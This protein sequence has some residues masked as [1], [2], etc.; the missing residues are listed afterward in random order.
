MKIKF[1]AV[2]NGRLKGIFTSWD[3]CEKS[4]KGYKGA[5]FKSFKLH[6][7]A[8]MFL[9]KYSKPTKFNNKKTIKKLKPLSNVK[10]TGYQRNKSKSGKLYRSI[11]RED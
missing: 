3:A 7:D 11:G 2:A 9:Q 4:V 6:G 10:T 1:Y 5:K 8:L